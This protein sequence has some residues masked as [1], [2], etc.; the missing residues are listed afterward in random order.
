MPNIALDTEA[1]RSITKLGNISTNTSVENVELV[2]AAS[3]T[4]ETS[5]NEEQYNGRDDKEEMQSQARARE[6]NKER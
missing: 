5:A 6:I 3:G 2:V 1:A 4:E